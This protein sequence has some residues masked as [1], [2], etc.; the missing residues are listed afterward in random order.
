MSAEEE[1]EGLVVFEL[2]GRKCGLPVS[3]VRGVVKARGIT[4]PS[5][6]QPGV[7]GSFDLEGTAIPVLTVSERLGLPAPEMLPTDHLV[8]ALA[9]ERLIAL[10][11]GRTVQLVYLPVRELRES[12][13]VCPGV[14]RVPSVSKLGEPLVVIEDLTQVIAAYELPLEPGSS[15]AGRP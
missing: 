3:A 6:S 15:E 1:I 5:S 2:S 14:A 8:M 9:G 12:A 4:E 11:V 13:A 10:R 7:T